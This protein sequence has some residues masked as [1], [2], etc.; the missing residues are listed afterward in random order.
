MMQKA[1]VGHGGN[2]MNKNVSYPVP[3]FED[4]LLI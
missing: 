3:I 1:V 2:K 4:R